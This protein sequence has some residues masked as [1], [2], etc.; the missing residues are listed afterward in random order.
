MA[1][2]LL[3][4]VESN[5]H[6]IPPYSGFTFFAVG[7]I[8]HLGFFRIHKLTSAGGTAPLQRLISSPKLLGNGTLPA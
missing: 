2:H 3:P 8:A 4:S 1:E 7:S 5:S 6:G